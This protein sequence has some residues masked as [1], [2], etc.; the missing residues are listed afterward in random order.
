MLKDRERVESI[1]GG[2]GEGT[3]GGV[4]AC[5]CVCV[6]ILY[7][8]DW[9]VGELIEGLIGRFY[10]YCT[11]RNESIINLNVTKRTKEVKRSQVILLR[12]IHSI[13]FS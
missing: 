3:I 7:V 9:F 8:T 5:V 2:S 11:S 4:Y 10:L 6:Y 12:H 13:L 1:E